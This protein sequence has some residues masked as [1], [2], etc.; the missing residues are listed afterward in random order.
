MNPIMVILG[1]EARGLSQSQLAESLGVDQSTLSRVE[2]GL[3]Q[4]SDEMVAKL[5]EILQFPISFFHQ[6]HRFQQLPVS[7]FRKRKRLS[8]RDVRAIRAKINIARLRIEILARSD[9][10]AEAKLVLKDL[11]ASGETPERAAMLLRVRWN[12]PP[13]P[14]PNLVKVIEDAGIVVVPTDFS[15]ALVDGVSLYEPDDT[16]PP[17][18]FINP[19]LPGDRM[20]WTLAYELAHIVL[21]H[22][23]A[24]PR[25]DDGVEDEANRFA[26]EFLTPARDIKGQLN[27]LNLQRLAALKSHWKVSMRA[28]LL[29][30]Q[31]FGCIS[32]RN[33]RHLWMRLSALGGTVEPVPLEPERPALVRSLVEHHLRELKYSMREMAALLH[34]NLDEFK[35][36]YLLHGGPLRLA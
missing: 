2:A 1:R 22:H 21:H 3:Q 14:I 11:R 30:A 6:S 24:I 16:L 25:D 17:M 8:S 10:L 7:F 31:Q 35:S 20:R 26:Q 36:E 23:L 28:L 12:L 4:P 5:S 9:S 34:Q 27:A 13:G 33:A 19:A 32:E 18:I 29:R 15:T